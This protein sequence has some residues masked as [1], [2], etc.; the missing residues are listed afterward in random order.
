MDGLRYRDAVSSLGRNDKS[1]LAWPFYLDPSRPHQPQTRESL[2]CMAARRTL[3]GRTDRHETLSVIGRGYA[4]NGRVNYP[5]G[6]PVSA[7][8][9][10]QLKNS[11]I[12]LAS[13]ISF[14]SIFS[15]C[16]LLKSNLSHAPA[17][18]RPGP[19]LIALAAFHRHNRDAR[20]RRC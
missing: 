3:K 6:C 9:T 19:V 20:G 4:V 18:G 17:P 11:N 13:L 8:R 12:L 14:F 16:V 1:G 15:P 7:S 10:K 2:A 5:A